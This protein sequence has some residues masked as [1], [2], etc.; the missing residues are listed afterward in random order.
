MPV[1]EE[2]GGRERYRRDPQR[3]TQAGSFVLRIFISFLQ[4]GILGEV[5]R[6]NRIRTFHQ[7]SRPVLSGS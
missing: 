2:E 7:L 6:E 4:A 5:S 1:G 3:G